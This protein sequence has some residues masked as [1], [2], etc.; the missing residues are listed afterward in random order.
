ML[1]IPAED[2][3]AM[4]TPR[5]KTA[6]L[7]Y[8]VTELLCT[9]G[10]G[11]G[12][13]AVL[14]HRGFHAYHKVPGKERHP[15]PG[16]AGGVPP[17]PWMRW[18]RPRRLRLNDEQQRALDGLDAAAPER[19]AGGGAAVRCDRQRQDPGLY[20]A[21]PQVL[22]KQ[23]KKALVLVPEIVLTPQLL[24]IFTSH[25]GEQVAVLHSS[26]RA[27]ERYDEWKRVGVKEQPTWWWAPAPRSSPL[28]T[29]WAHHPGR[30]AGEQL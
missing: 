22:R 15:H 14:F 24:R 11:L 27:G 13:R 6:P 7:R 3:M 8:S 4:V 5:R 25:F 10:S 26:L 19:K 29:T 16:G 18:T 21:D 9:L 12:Q 1:A 17:P 30:G 28:W 20:P 2:A 23:G